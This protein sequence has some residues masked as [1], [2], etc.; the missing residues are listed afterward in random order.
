MD[1]AE[2]ESDYTMRAFYETLATRLRSLASQLESA[3]ILHDNDNYH[4]T[5]DDYAFSQYKAG[6]GTPG[7][8]EKA[9]V[10]RQFFPRS[11]KGS[12]D[13]ETPAAE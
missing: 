2:Y 3:K 10:L 12:D 13:S 8:A 1:W 6:A 11:G 9:A 5:L 4:D 7:A